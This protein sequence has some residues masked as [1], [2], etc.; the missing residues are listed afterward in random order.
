MKNVR[1]AL[2]ALIL[3]CF[4]GV[5]WLLPLDTASALGGWIGRTIGPR[6]AA[7]RKARRHLSKALPELS[8]SEQDK[9]IVE[10]WDNLG[11]VIA[12]YPHLEKIGRERT[13]IENLDLVEKYRA[14]GKPILFLATHL[15]NWEVNATA[16]Y[17]QID[18][19]ITVTY[20]APNN[21]LSDKLLR[22]AR[23]LNEKIGALPKARE[24]GRHLV[25]IIK[26]KSYLGIMIDQKYNEGIAAPFF[27]IPAKTNPIFVTLAQKYKC[28]TLC[29]Q[30]IRT[31]GA[32]FKMILSE[33]L[34]FF[35]D[36]GAPRPAESVIADAH[37]MQEKWFAENPGQWMWLHRRWDNETGDKND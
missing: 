28:P 34:S 33:P 4:Y 31:K 3:Y 37:K 26:N 7:S 22:R 12:E 10:M 36:N 16:L 8:G 5:F 13:Q 30:C 15:A 24:S 1:Y 18:L 25:N 6:L 32:N 35:D 19:P 17:K 23:T 2:E 29:G 21:P 27:G 14:E 20:R 11:R 9:I